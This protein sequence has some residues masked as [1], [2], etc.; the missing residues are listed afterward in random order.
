MEYNEYMQNN[1]YIPITEH[2]MPDLIMLTYPR[3]GRHWLYWNTI[4]NTN[5]KVNFFHGMDQ[6]IGKEYYINNISVPIATVVRSPEACLAS[7]NTMEQNTQFDH[8]LNDYIDHYEFIIEHADLLFLYE[9]LREKTPEILKTMCDKFG[10][11]I[12]G[13]NHNFQDYEKW[14]KETQNP[15]KLITSKESILYQDALKKAESLDL[16]RHTELYLAAKS[17]A[18]KL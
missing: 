4:T 15:F 12:L 16:S 5:L 6:G 2:E 11:R 14:Y 8:R 1:K 17:K 10:G 13:S 18:V 7:I 9:D 3:S